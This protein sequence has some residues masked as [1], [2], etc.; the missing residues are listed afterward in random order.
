VEQATIGYIL[1][2]HEIG[3]LLKYKTAR[4]GSTISS[5]WCPWAS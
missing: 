5:I 2:F 3:H 4:N 1:E